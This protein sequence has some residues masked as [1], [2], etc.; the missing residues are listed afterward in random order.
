VNLVA[1]AQSLARS[2]SVTDTHAAV[3]LMCVFGLGWAIVE[4]VFGT[5]MR[6]TYDLMQVV[7]MRYA[8]HLLIVLAVWGWRRPSRIW[9]TARPV[10]HLTRSLMMLIMPLSFAWAFT[11]GAPL[12]FTWA[13]FW[14]SP[15]IVALLAMVWW[16]ER[17]S[18][19][20]WACL[21]A[22]VIG[23]VVLELPAVPHSMAA[24]VAPLMMAS[25]FSVYVMMT[26]S[27]REER[28]ETNLFYTA[29]GV[30]LLLS[31][32]VPGVWVTPSV[33]DMVM[34]AG[35][36][37][38][39][40]IAL[41]AL[42]RAVHRGPI[43]VATPAMYVQVACT[44]IIGALGAHHMLSPPLLVGVGLIFAACALTWKFPGAFRPADARQE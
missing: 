41:L 14:L 38:F 3:L 15:V 12:S 34:V 7:W 39:G 26:R 24:V 33:H 11:H 30:F 21:V 6:Q 27:L 32:Y 25:S 22:G 29:I 17:P 5:H 8:V 42:D 4:T 40:F 2:A 18:R 20:T 1:R 44:A 35:I 9:R 36:G 43:S 31:L 13:V 16:R 10:Y 28:L 23:V 19:I 37:S